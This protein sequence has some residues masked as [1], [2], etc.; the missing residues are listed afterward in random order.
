[1]RHWGWF[2]AVALVLFAGTIAA[3][4]NGIRRGKIKAVDADKHTVTIT[5]DGKDETFTLTDRT[6]VMDASNQP[7]KEPFKDLASGAAVMF[8]ADTRN[9]RTVLVGVKLAGDAA[10]RRDAPSR[11]DTSHLK[12]LNELGAGQH[13]G[14]EGGFYPGGR[15]DRP[16][17]HE[18][19]GLALARQVRPLDADGKPSPD[20]EIVLLSI[21]M[22][23]TVQSSMGFQRALAGE[24]DKNPR[25]QF[26][27]GAEGGQTA[28]ITQDP[29]DNGRGAHYWAGVDQKL[30]KAGVTRAQ[31]QAVWIKQADARPTEPFPKHAQKLQAEL[32]NIVRVLHD[33]FPNLKLCYLTSR[34]YGGY[35]KTALNPEPYAYESG[36]AVK[37]LIEQQIKGDPSLNHDPA[38][39]PVKA[40][41]L[42]WGPYFW[43]NGKTPRA[44]GLTYDEGD[45]AADGTHQSPSGQAK[46]G[47][48]MLQFFK[49]DSTAKAW[50][51]APKAAGTE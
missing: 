18:A 12:P 2:A 31:V 21:G 7:V 28:A 6:R 9:G 8:K 47:K 44:D 4:D 33:R 34:T 36:F 30:R 41:W 14:Y 42:S 35:A 23:N 26:V 15:N 22:S 39:G 48:L 40:P 32:A 37:W 17:A 24:A 5:A 3:Q 45:F 46:V 49:T 19:A 29:N 27:N 20:G 50:F 1:M 51:L 38:Q 43:A 10:A 11:F 16:A 13:Q 25:V